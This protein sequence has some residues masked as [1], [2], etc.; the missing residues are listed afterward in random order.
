MDYQ[1]SEKMENVFLMSYN[2]YGL[3]FKYEQL[4]KLVLNLLHIYN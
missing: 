2:I 3:K 4:I 1:L